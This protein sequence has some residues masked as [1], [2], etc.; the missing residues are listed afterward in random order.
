MA[1]VK[2]TKR[3]YFEMVLDVVRDNEE[4]A[5]FIE[6]EIAAMDARKAKDAERRAAKK[7]EPD[8]IIE[9]VASALTD[10]FATAEDITESIG[11][12]EITRGKVVNRLGKLV[13]AGKAEKD[14]VKVGKA[15]KTVYRAVA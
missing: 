13:A 12:E 5:A 7:A 14:V 4:L 15:R 2:V 9:I 1:E 10:E 8:E 3:D 11:N 6:K